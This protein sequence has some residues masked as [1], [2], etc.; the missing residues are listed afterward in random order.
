MGIA[1]HILAINRKQGIIIRKREKTRYRLRWE[2]ERTF[3]ILEW[4]L[5]CEK[6]R[7]V[8]NR[9]YNVTISERIVAYNCTFMVNQIKKRTKKEIIDIII[10][11]I[12]GHHKSK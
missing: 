4:I 9:N 3:S 6:I 11:R 1:L 7:C 5:H 2:I 12:I 10:C 8:R